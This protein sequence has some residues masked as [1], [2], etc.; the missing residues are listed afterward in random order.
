MAHQR[1]DG[2]RGPADVIT[3]LPAASGRLFHSSTTSQASLPGLDSPDNHLVASIHSIY[4]IY[5]I[6]HSVSLELFDT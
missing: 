6:A 4:S 2:G 5:C 1:R 3:S